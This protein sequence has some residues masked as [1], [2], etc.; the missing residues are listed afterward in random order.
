MK[1]QTARKYLQTVYLKMDS[2]LGYTENSQSSTVKQT[3]NKQ[4][5][6]L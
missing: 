4:T 1:V 5:I 6:Q 3:T 2:Y